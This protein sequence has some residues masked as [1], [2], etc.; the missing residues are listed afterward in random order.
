MNSR[1]PGRPRPRNHPTSN[2]AR[3][4]TLRAMHGLDPAR[5]TWHITWGTYGTRL[6]GGERPT[7]DRNH[8]QLGDPFVYHDPDR[9]ARERN[10]M[11][12]APVHPTTQQQEFIER[13]IPE[14]CIRG[15]WNLRTCSADHDHVH[16][17]LDIPRNIHGERVRRI[18]KR[19]L[20]Q[21]LDEHWSRPKS[22]TWWAE[23]GSNKVVRDD[24]YLNNV[25]PYIEKQRVENRT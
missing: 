5:T 13:S 9:E 25:F 23:Q 18:L 16:V 21:A 17:L 24:A 2:R 12:A 1:E 15:G 7:V 8:N 3:I 11:R 14:L 19:W 6:H 4:V 10:Q 20:T 22:G